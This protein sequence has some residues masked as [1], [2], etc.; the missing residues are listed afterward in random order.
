[1]R[2]ILDALQAIFP[3]ITSPVA[4]VVDEPAV[5]AGGTEEGN[6]QS[7]ED[8]NKS[9][10]SRMSAINSKYSAAVDN[11]SQQ[12]QYLR[13]HQEQAQ[14]ADEDALIQAD[15]GS[16]A[17]LRTFLQTFPELQLCECFPDLEN[18]QLVLQQYG[19]FNSKEEVHG[20]QVRSKLVPAKRRA[21]AGQGATWRALAQDD[22]KA[23]L[24]ASSVRRKAMSHTMPKDQW[25]LEKKYGLMH[26]P[27]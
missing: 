24:A 11:F 13:S 21:E 15:S 23:R 18:P 20:M 10:S 7:V 25:D 3:D 1:M 16:E 27:L 19:A 5:V 17:L 12:Q 14:K 2:P 22:L 4:S 26:P 8:G 9:Y 6:Q